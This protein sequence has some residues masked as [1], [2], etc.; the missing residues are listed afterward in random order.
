M[1]VLLIPTFLTRYGRVGSISGL[2]FLLLVGAPFAAAH[3]IRTLQPQPDE[4]PGPPGANLSEAPDDPLFE[5]HRVLVD[6]FPLLVRDGEAVVPPLGRRNLQ[7]RYDVAD[8]LPADSVVFRFQMEGLEPAWVDAGD[9]TVAFYRHI[10]PGSY[11]FRVEAREGHG[12]WVLADSLPVYIEP[13]FYETGWFLALVVGLGLALVGGVV[14]YLARQAQLLSRLVGQRTRALEDEK[15]RA[16]AALDLARAAQDEAEAARAEA[17]AARAEAEEAWAEAEQAR[18]QAEAMLAVTEEQSLQLL[19]TD[20]LKSR[21][22]ANLSHEFRTPLTLIL[23]PLERAVR[24]EL[25]DLDEP[26]GYARHV[27]DIARLNALRLLRLIN[28]LLDLSKLEGG[29]MELRARKGDLVAFLHKAVDLFGSE[30]ERLGVRL[31]FRPDADRLP[32]HFDPEK[33]EKIVSNLLANA[34]KADA[35]GGKV[36]VSVRTV[37]PHTVPDRLLPFLEAAERDATDLDWL[38]EDRE[39]RLSAERARRLATSGYAEITVRDTGIGIEPEKLPHIFDRFY[40]TDS[41]GT[42]TGIG[43]SLVNELVELH[44]GEVSVESQPGFGSTFTLRLPLGTDHL[45]EHERIEPQQPEP[46]EED[47]FSAG[48]FTPEA[49]LLAT[50]NLSAVPLVDPFDVPSARPAPSSFGADDDR[51]LILVVDDHADL[52]AMIR[53][54]LEP[55]Y[56]VA[57]AISGEQALRC[58]RELH[59][60]LVVSDIIMPGIDGLELCRRVRAD[61]NLASIPIVLLT[62]R[63]GDESRIQGYDTGADDYLTKPFLGDE[64]RARVANL[65]RRRRIMRE[66]FSQELVVELFE[67]PV[68]SA[69]AA[70]VERVFAVIDEHLGDADFT[71]AQLAEGVGVSQSQLKRKLRAIADQS[72]VEVV[73]T[74]RLERAAKLLDGRAG[75]VS[76]V[77]Y[78]VGF[79]SVSYFSKVFRE[80][81]GK[82]PSQVLAD[83]LDS[84]DET[85]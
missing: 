60:D 40:Q 76:E 61:E 69:D 62:A 6:D 56:R 39:E 23:D 2:A 12:R 70:F 75:T 10:D 66:R 24:G 37:A 74:Y 84:V 80:H 15:E 34:L 68:R 33:L 16:E 32:L 82:L 41:G 85:A 45:A 78:E 20:H 5:I 26:D 58:I 7:F 65:L 52:R 17:E 3:G 81:T 79:H 36:L 49:P 64:L 77:A 14:W 27:F 54:H 73:R 13:Y 4:R 51:P 83:A 63:G 25:G 55:H 59:P 31:L 44:R 67:R 35:D 46:S 9:R 22:F 11:T 50:H 28:Q 38:G 57:E 18:A 30:A 29:G 72:P 47:L 1:S 43:L 42:G 48:D 19:R 53:S 8:T 21:L 71:V